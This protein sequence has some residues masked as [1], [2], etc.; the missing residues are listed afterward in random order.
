MIITL[1]SFTGMKKRICF[2]TCQLIPKVAAVSPK[3]LDDESIFVCH[4]G[5][6]SLFPLAFGLFPLDSPQTLET[7]DIVI[8]PDELWTP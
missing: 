8:D 1:K 6:M 5:Y 2:V 3:T 4:K 7:L